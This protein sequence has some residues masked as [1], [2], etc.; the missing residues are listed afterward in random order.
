MSTC[1]LL[2]ERPVA[3]REN[4]RHNAVEGA[5]VPTSFAFQ[6]LRAIFEIQILTHDPQELSLGFA[7]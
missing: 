5:Q 4:G 6:C 3:E 7:K 1:H 2:S